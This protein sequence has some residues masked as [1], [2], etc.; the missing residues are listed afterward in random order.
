MRKRFGN[1]HGDVAFNRG[2]SLELGEFRLR[3]IGVL[4]RI[5]IEL[6]D[7]DAVGRVKFARL[8][9]RKL[10]R[11]ADR[12]SVEKNLSGK[13]EILLLS[14][15]ERKRFRSDRFERAFQ[16]EKVERAFGRRAPMHAPFDGAG[17]EKAKAPYFAGIRCQKNAA[18]LENAE[19]AFARADV[20]LEDFQKARKQAGPKGD[21][22]FAQWIL[23]IDGVLAKSGRVSRN[24][25]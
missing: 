4:Q 5:E 19:T 23:Q 1:D 14:A 20:V 24:E 11:K 12:L 2:E 25:F 8:P 21:M 9:G 22:V 13:R 6:G 18:D 15:P 16:V 10:P 3:C 7:E 17:K